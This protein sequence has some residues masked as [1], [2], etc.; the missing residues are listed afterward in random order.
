MLRDFEASTMVYEYDSVNLPKNDLRCHGLMILS[1]EKRIINRLSI[2]KRSQ[3]DRENGLIRI[4][5]GPFYDRVA[6]M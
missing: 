6:L 4:W 3:S 1:E 2:I 5:Q